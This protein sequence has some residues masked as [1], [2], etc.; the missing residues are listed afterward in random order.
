MSG[1]TAASFG[2]DAGLLIAFQAILAAKAIADG[3]ATEET[4]RAEVSGT[5]EAERLRR[6]EAGLAERR[7]LADGLAREESRL[8]RLM[9]ARDILAVQLGQ[10]V[11][12]IESA[13]RPADGDA[14]AQINYL[15]SLQALTETLA[16]EVADLS[17]RSVKA[18]SAADL[19]ALV[20]AAPTL[21]EQLAAFEA[22]A[23]LSSQVPRSV[24]AERRA[25]A[26][27]IIG[28]AAIVAGAS[29]PVELE[30]L[31]AELMRTLSAERAAAVAT[32]LRLRVD[33][34]NEEAAAQ[35][36]ALV[37][38][39]SLRDL[40]YAVDGIGETLFVEGGVAHFQRPGWRD[41]FVRLRVD[42]K[43]A[44]L[45]FNVVR[46]DTGS[47]DRKQ[48]DM[49]AEERWCAEF[50]RL[51][52]TLA[53]RGLRVS[54]THMLGAGEVPVQTVDSAVL[55]KLCA[56]EEWSDDIETKAMRRP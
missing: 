40:G 1:P 37:L 13:K 38:E 43:R 49:L 25:L 2:L 30:S 55:P 9:T 48:E 8:R 54:V 51:E 52:E 16:S 6:R 17:A 33:R 15:K 22:Q 46:A 12:V 47:L 3:Y 24:V 23:N 5:R 18:V 4:R 29:L 21:D 39:Q 41:Y 26:E 35:A 27:R 50:P 44:T 36:A 10:T 11:S 32:E 28:R 56:E 31:I 42:A 53:A 19:A 20:A 14:P 7:A 34:H 45:N